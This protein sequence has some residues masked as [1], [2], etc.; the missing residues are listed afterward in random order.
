MKVLDCYAWIRDRFQDVKEDGAYVSAACPLK[1]HRNA[2]LRFWLG[3]TGQLC[4]RCWNPECSKLEILRAVGLSFK[5][6]F[7]DALI[8]D[9]VKREMV[10]RY[11]YSDESNTALY[12]I[13][14]FEPGWRGKDKDLRPRYSTPDGWVWGLPKEIRRV[15][16][17]LPQILAAEPSRTVLVV[18][19]E[20]DCDAL[21]RL[22]VLATTNVLGESSAWLAEYSRA[23]SGRSVVV[24]P[25]ADSAGER[26]ADEV[27]GSLIR[28]GVGSVRVA[29]LPVKDATAF[30]N[31]LRVR[32]LTDPADLRRELWA[33]LSEADHWIPKR[34]GQLCVSR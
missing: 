4:F 34:K 18:A 8:P 22:D 20:K 14:R 12:E 10:A 26:H 32:G 28:H 27:V 23:L 15:L 6:C 33:E 5:D 25:D 2:C 24:V 31:G 30:L 16:Y 3:S 29:Q 21:D 17:R 19:G 7:P 9:D 1:C 13:V 11:T